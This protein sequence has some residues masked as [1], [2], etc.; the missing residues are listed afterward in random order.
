VNGWSLERRKIWGHLARIGFIV[1]PIAGMGGAVGLKGTD[2]T[3]VL[4]EAVKRGA[5]PVSPRRAK[6]FLSIL[7]KNPEL[8]FV[9][10]EGQMGGNIAKDLDVEFVSLDSIGPETTRADTVRIARSML[11]HG[12]DILVFVGGDGTAKDVLEAVGEGVTVLGVP[13]GVKVYSSVFAINPT[14]AANLILEFQ[15]GGTETVK[16]EVLDIDES[17]FREGRLAISLKGYLPTPQAGGLMQNPK[18][19]SVLSDNEEMEAI[20]DYFLE[21]LIDPSTVYVLGPGLTVDRIARRLGVTKKTLLGVDVVRG[22]GTILVLDAGE[23]EILSFVEHS[24][25][26][27]I[28]SPIGGQG[29]FLG[30]GNQQISPRVIRKVGID[31]LIIFATK[32]KMGM[33]WPRRLLVDSGDSDLDESLR[34]YRRIIIGY[35]EEMMVKIE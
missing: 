32:N 20:A 31:G 9:V 26:R 1:N 17:E 30:R 19:P 8:S 10:A 15:A 3:T 6:E 25:A 34:G 14:A 13:A 16:G 29:F 23:T 21:E 33:L 2:G 27:I 12:I 28:V 11:K 18:V 35:R 24:K 5:I 22:D 4:Q 7:G